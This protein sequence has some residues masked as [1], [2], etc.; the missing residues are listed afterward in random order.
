MNAIH[1]AEHGKDIH[2]D[3]GKDRTHVDI[4]VGIVNPKR[5]RLFISNT[6]LDQMGCEVATVT[7]KG[8]TAST[9]HLMVKNTLIFR[10]VNQ[11]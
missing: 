10:I 11:N 9:T 8:V 1:T 4:D 3:V 5:Q 2:Y 7:S 6:I